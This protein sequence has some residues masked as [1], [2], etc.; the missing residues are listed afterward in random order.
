MATSR[1]FHQ[2]TCQVQMNVLWIT[3][4]CIKTNFCIQNSLI[5]SYFCPL[6]HHHTTKKEEIIGIRDRTTQEQTM[7]ISSIHF[8]P[9]FTHIQQF[10][11][12]CSPWFG[13]DRWTS[14]SKM[15]RVQNSFKGMSII[16]SLY[17]IKFYVKELNF[18]SYK[19]LKILLDFISFN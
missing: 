3:M 16:Q 19:F 6:S 11:L 15:F 1:N 10:C 18:I 4:K 8:S 7:K 17:R 12:T 2:T 14:C 13:I 5:E 9:H